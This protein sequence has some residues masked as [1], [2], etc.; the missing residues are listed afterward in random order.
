MIMRS[1]GIGTRPVYAS[2]KGHLIDGP[3]WS[4]DGKWIAFGLHDDACDSAGGSITVIRPDGTGMRDVT[5]PC[6]GNLN[7]ESA[8]DSDPSWSPDGKQLA[9][10]RLTW[11]CA[12]CDQNEIFMSNV[13][14]SNVHWVTTDTS[15]E[16]S[17]PA[18]S[19]DGQQLAAQIG[20]IALLDLAGNT[21]AQLDPSGTEPAWQPLGR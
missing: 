2:A 21:L 14:G 6:S 4:P 17:N 19:P 18:W 15:Y 12:R 16:S 5:G 11:L 8:D 9:F 10:T 3:A 20:G 1:N 7:G 13:D